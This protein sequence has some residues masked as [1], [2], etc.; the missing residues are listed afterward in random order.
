[1]DVER[2]G[3][4]FGLRVRIIKLSDSLELPALRIPRK[5]VGIRSYN[6]ASSEMKPRGVS[7]VAKGL[8]FPREEGNRLLGEH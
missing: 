1:M 7:T 8:D 4:S 6:E 3:S 5:D 2:G